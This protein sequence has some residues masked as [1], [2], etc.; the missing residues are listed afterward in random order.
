LISAGF[1]ASLHV[2]QR[3]FGPRFSGIVENF[4]CSFLYT[5]RELRRCRARAKASNARATARIG[6]TGPRP[7][8]ASCG[9][10]RKKSHTKIETKTGPVKQLISVPAKYDDPDYRA[11]VYEMWMKKA[12]EA[13]AAYANIDQNLYYGSRMCA[14]EWRVD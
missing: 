1:S 5:W 11:W 9:N 8:S 4:Y 7:N 2:L 12:L 6:G 13:Q 14:N 10:Q 3:V